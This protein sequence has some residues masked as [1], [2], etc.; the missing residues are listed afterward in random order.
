MS[1]FWLTGIPSY[2]LEVDG[3]VGLATSGIVSRCAGY[4]PNILWSILQCLGTHECVCEPL[5]S[6]VN[7]AVSNIKG[8]DMSDATLWDMSGAE[9]ELPH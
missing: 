5:A 6:S 8:P 3:L 9:I 2:K 4:K 7:S 1:A